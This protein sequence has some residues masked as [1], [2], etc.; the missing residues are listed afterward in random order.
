M[1]K[2]EHYIPQFLL[3]NFSVKRK[4]KYHTNIY[5]ISRDQF[6]RNQDIR[7]VCARRFLYDKDN[8]VEDILD[9]YVERPAAEVISRLLNS[10]TSFQ[11]TQLRELLRFI[12]VQL[13]RTPGYFKESQDFLNA[14]T[15][16]I[17]KEW[18]RLNGYPIS[19]AE[20]LRLVPTEARSVY[21][22]LTLD[23]VFNWLLFADLSLHVLIN[24]TKDEFIL[25]DHPVVQYNWFLRDDKSPSA[26]SVTNRGLQIF[27]PISSSI[28]CCLY[29]DQVYCYGSGP[30]HFT[31][32]GDPADIEI[33]NS[34]QSLNATD[35][36][37]CKSEA[38][39]TSLSTLGRRYSQVQ[40][41]ESH[42]SNTPASDAGAGRLSSIHFVWRTQATVPQ[43]PSFVNIRDEL[44]GIPP[45]C[46]ERRPDIVEGHS[47]LKK[48]I[49]GKT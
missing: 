17:F 6:R 2:N 33:L 23:S 18:A 41:F 16:T 38:M 28:T 3:K 20:R 45:E 19:S 42:A 46:K 37:I 11:G 24:A 9:R 26:T 21:A 12:S 8:F 32:L 1:V 48:L 49:W 4:R 39:E 30:E 22:Y 29:D 5:D 44:Q 13:A 40:L 35:F 31:I 47:L 25:S 34:F 36:L 15:G 10:P 14:F 7:R 43:M 27:L